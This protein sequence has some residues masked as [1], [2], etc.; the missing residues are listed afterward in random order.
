MA[1]THLKTLLGEGRPAGVALTGGFHWAFWVCGTIALLAL[2]VAATLIGHKTV[3]AG[4]E[5]AEKF[6]PARWIPSRARITR[7]VSTHLHPQA[8]VH[9]ELHTTD[10]DR[11]GTGSER[12]LLEAAP[13]R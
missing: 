3:P 10:Q 11:A 12:E 7:R 2:P 13:A 6:A 4:P 8:R 5:P 9:L 1:A